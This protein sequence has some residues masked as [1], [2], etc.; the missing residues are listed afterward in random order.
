MV[1]LASLLAADLGV[2]AH[3]VVMAWSVRTQNRAVR[4]YGPSQRRVSLARVACKG[5][6]TVQVQDP[7]K[8]K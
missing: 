6:S 7:L 8:I 2:S 1:A 3:S 4:S 5:V